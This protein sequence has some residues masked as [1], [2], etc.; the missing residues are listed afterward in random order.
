MTY[1]DK[2]RQWRAELRQMADQLLESDDP[3]QAQRVVYAIAVIK[4]VH[5]ELA[6]LGLDECEWLSEGKRG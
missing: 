6:S 5:N 3:E 4:R 1:A 2:L